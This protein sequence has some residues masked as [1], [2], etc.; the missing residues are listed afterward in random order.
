M[1]LLVCV[2]FVRLPRQISDGQ[3]TAMAADDTTSLS[4]VLAHLAKKP[5]Y[6][7]LAHHTTLKSWSESI[8]LRCKP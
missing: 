5:G 2:K 3:P 4:L 6:P 1:T 7:E 8:A